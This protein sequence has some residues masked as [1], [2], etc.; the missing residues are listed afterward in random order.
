MLVGFLG[1][2]AWA[3]AL[4]KLLSDNNHQVLLWSIEND[5]LDSLEKSGR[6]PKFEKV[7]FQN[8]V[9]VTRN[10]EDILTCDVVVECV[11]AKGLRS[12]FNIIIK[13]RVN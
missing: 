12:V 6:H 7:S 9:N 8:N 10:I 2:G 1:S 3:M 4:I 5:V 11:T 13:G